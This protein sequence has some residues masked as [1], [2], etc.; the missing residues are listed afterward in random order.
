MEESYLNKEICTACGGGCC[1]RAPGIYIPSDFKE[2]ITKDFILNL[3]KNNKNIAIDWWDGGIMS[4]DNKDTY[5]LRPTIKGESNIK[6][7]WG[8]QCINWSKE[9]GCS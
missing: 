2:P 4:T 9:I 6:G 1:K 8:G 3:L 7:S 5:Y